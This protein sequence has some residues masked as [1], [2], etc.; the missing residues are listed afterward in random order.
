V[1]ATLCSAACLGPSL[2]YDEQRL[3]KKCDVTGRDEVTL[4]QARCIARVAGLKE[5]RKCPF[6]LNEFTRAGGTSVIAVRETCSTLALEI[7]RATGEVV[8]VAVGAGDAP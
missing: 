3:Q 4:E 6:E 5:G 8:A 2:K 1:L 7:D